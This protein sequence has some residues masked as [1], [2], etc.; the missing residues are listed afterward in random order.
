[1]VPGWGTG[2]MTEDLK[3]K[4]LI[5][6][7]LAAILLI[8]LAGALPR[9]ELQLGVPLPAN[10]V[11]SGPGTPDALPQVSISIN[12]FFKA[13]LGVILL[14]VLLFCFYKALR[15]AHWK[16]LLVPILTI[17]VGTLV[18][19]G[20]LALLAN[21]NVSIIPD[22]PEILP[23]ALPIPRAPAGPLPLDFTWLAGIALALGVIGVGLWLALRR[24]EAPRAMAAL[25]FEAERALQDILAGLDL[26]GVIIQ[27]YQQMSQALQQERGIELEET[28]TAREFERLLDTRGFPPGPVH[29][30]TRL[31]ENARYGSHPPAPGDEKSALDCLEQIVAFCRLAGKPGQA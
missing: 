8:V 10:D 31:F 11:K 3:R 5:F 13:V 1:M 30:L 9:L 15:G 6:I 26:R 28:M 12:T 16:E 2:I 21:V 17:M 20:L 25:Q 29:Q 19:L 14:L 18:I 7:A 23:T 4:T 22:Q 24:K 27:C